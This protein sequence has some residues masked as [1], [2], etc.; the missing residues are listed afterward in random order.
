MD[1]LHRIRLGTNVYNKILNILLAALLIGQ[2]G[3]EKIGKQTAKGQISVSGQVSAET[4]Q[5]SGSISPPSDFPQI[6]VVGWIDSKHKYDGAAY[7]RNGALTHLTDGT[8]MEAVTVS[9][10][11]IYLAGIQRIEDG[12]PAYEQR[13]TMVKVWKNGVPTALTDGTTYCQ[14][15][16]IAVSG[17]DVYVV[18]QMMFGGNFAPILWK[19]GNLTRLADKGVARS[20]AISEGNVY[21]AGWEWRHDWEYPRAML[22]KNGLGVPIS[23]GTKT[24]DAVSVA[25]SANEVYVAFEESQLVGPIT[26][27]TISKIWRNGSSTPLR[28]GR[29]ES[30][31]VKSLAISGKNVYATGWVVNKN[32]EKSRAITWKN[33][34]PSNLRDSGSESRPN[35]I[36]LDGEDVYVVGDD[37][38]DGHGI[39]KLW[40]NGVATWL[41]KE[42]SGAK[43]IF[44][45]GSNRNSQND[46]LPQTKPAETGGTLPGDL[47]NRF[48]LWVSQSQVPRSD[49]SGFYADSVDYYRVKGMPKSKL[50]ADKASFWKKY[51]RLEIRIENLTFSPGPGD[52]W[53]C[54]YD[55]H[56]D[57]TK[58]GSGGHYT[59]HTRS[60]LV[61]QKVRGTWLIC[62]EK[63][64]KLVSANGGGTS[65]GNPKE[66]QVLSNLAYNKTGPYAPEIQTLG[67]SWT[68]TVLSADR[69]QL[70]YTDVYSIKRNGLQFSVT[71]LWA[72]YEY[73]VPSVQI[74]QVLFSG[75]D[76]G[77]FCKLGSV[78]DLDWATGKS[79]W[80]SPPHT[81][82]TPL[83]DGTIMS[84]IWKLVSRVSPP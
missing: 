7:W 20:V 52:G 74:R 11:D 38:L 70:V 50:L 82:W 14:V 62:A 31:Y 76:R 69:T 79:R 75:S 17:S 78:S 33:S 41:A 3:C 46:A 1:F 63:D 80:T 28:S 13:N 72:S 30:S 51:E 54:E 49:V 58:V 27:N 29:G 71:C 26:W 10:K 56:F 73:S 24:G 34:L 18:G 47:K 32:S 4:P 68:L 77:L 60:R 8:F 53:T 23:D 44:V 65:Q 83:P 64:D 81:D 2:I 19:N 25:V 61:F 35:S 48:D 84:D 12:R 43:M 6:H 36:F 45:V 5:E 15:S 67:R 37:S 57:G 22:W 66:S 16:S 39:A 21:V 42:N 9:G 40:K 55:K 59:G